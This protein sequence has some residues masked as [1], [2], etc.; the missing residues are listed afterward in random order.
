MVP[1]RH[2]RIL[3]GGRGDTG[4][5]ANLMYALGADATALCKIESTRELDKPRSVD[6]VSGQT[7]T[8]GGMEKRRMVRK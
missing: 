1:P 4:R 2:N 6:L 3:G 5:K 7:I 8:Q